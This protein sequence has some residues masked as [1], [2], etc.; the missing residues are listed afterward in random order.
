[1]CDSVVQDCTTG[2]VVPVFSSLFSVCIYSIQ[3]KSW[4]QTPPTHTQENKT[5]TNCLKLVLEVVF[6]RLRLL[7]LNSS[8]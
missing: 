4:K 3:V 8:Y 1:M 6:I 2:Y 5:T 7:S